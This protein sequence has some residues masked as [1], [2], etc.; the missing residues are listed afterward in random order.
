MQVPK[1]IAI[2]PDGNRRWAK[3]QGLHVTKGHEHAA[4]K[5]H[6]IDLFLRAKERGVECITL[7][8]FSTENWKRNKFEIDALFKL[9]ERTLVDLA[10]QCEEH[11]IRFKWFGR[12]DRVAEKLKVE[13][14]KVEAD[15]AS[16]DSFTLGMCLDYG[17]RDELL[18]AV[19]K[20]KAQDVELTEDNM[21]EFL[22]TAGVPDPDIVVRTSGEMRL[23]GFMSWQLAYS[24][25]HFMDK[26]FPDFTVEDID[27]V[28]DE[29]S[30]RQ[31]RFGGG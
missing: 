20:A 24:E 17:G 21:S 23:S 3:N 18:R 14:E 25:L 15:T 8:V 30:S 6:L 16:Y 10:E 2:I 26:H 9:L 27:V 29:F 19:A 5:D 28:I 1:H 4:R 11:Q 7:W 12:R 22:D 13:L 31:R